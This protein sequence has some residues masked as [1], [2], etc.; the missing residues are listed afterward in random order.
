MSF[1]FPGRFVVNEWK[2]ERKNEWTNE[3]MNESMK[4]WEKKTTVIADFFSLLNAI[5]TAFS[6]SIIKYRIYASDY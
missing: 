5:L 3:Q 1:L 2:E 4:E 6:I